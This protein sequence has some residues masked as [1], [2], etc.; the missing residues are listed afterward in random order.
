MYPLRLQL[1]NE[2]LSATFGGEIQL[3]CTF[4]VATKL[5]VWMLAEEKRAAWKVMIEWGGCAIYHLR[6]KQQ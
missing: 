3:Q 4:K 5:E 1:L 6:T 2:S